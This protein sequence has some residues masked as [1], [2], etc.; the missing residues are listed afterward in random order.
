L[1]AAEKRQSVS[2]TG[3]VAIDALYDLLK[4][5]GVCQLV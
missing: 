2:L 5:P 1:R 4:I 3:E